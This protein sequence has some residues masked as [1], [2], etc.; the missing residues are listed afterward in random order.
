MVIRALSYKIRVAIT[1]ALFISVAILTVSITASLF[2]EKLYQS[3]IEHSIEHK[4]AIIVD[5]V[6]SQYIPETDCFNIAGLQALG[7][8]YVHEGFIISVYDANGDLVWDAQD[9]DEDQCQNVLT[10]IDTANDKSNILRVE[11]QT[12]YYDSE[13]VG[14][15]EIE[16]YGPMFYTS[17]EAHFIEMLNKLLIVIGVIFALVSAILS[18][19]L[20]TKVTKPITEATEA[21][22]KIAEGDWSVRLPE[23]KYAR[24]LNDLA[25][26]L[27]GIAISLENGEKWQRQLTR[28]VAHELRTP[29]TALQGNLEGMI[30]GIIEPTQ[31]RIEKCHSEVLRLNSLIDDLNQLSLLERDN[32]KLQ[33]EIGDLSEILE[34]VVSNF[35]IQAEQ[36]GLQINLVTDA[37]P[38]YADLT[39][40]SQVFVNLVSNAIKYTDY[41]EINIFIIEDNDNYI[42]EVSDTGI[43]ISGNNL[44]KIF[45]RLYRADESR[46]RDTGGSGIGLSI[47][48]K[49]VIAHGGEINIESEIGIGTTFKIS[50]PKVNI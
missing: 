12:L 41:G 39:R 48:E 49:I 26:S 50:L 3:H 43:G 17:N 45:G 42:V 4:N 40:L 24:E 29:L 27:N 7:M 22:E 44:S 32:L 2:A 13:P 46:S 8:S 36:K 6:T 23:N 15:V 28:D 34:T 33:M 31:E 20:A 37:A 1:Y 9:C 5:S 30:D 16:S 21:A 10:E 18:I 35:K 11:T 14:T 25:T 47:V 38:I 19:I